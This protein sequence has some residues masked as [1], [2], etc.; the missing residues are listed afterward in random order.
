MPS[1]TWV[2]AQNGGAPWQTANGTTLSTAATATISPTTAGTGG[3]AEIFQFYQGQVFRVTASGI[4]TMGSTATN[5]TFALFASVTGTAAS[6]GTS[7]AS[8]GAFALPVSVTNLYWTIDLM[9]QVRAMAQGTGTATI[10]TSGALRLQTATFAG[11][12][13]CAVLPMPATA[14]PTAA[15]VDTTI[16][17]TMALVGT[18]SQVTGSP[19]ITCT[20]FL[21][22]SV[23]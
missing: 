22:E 3:D 10:S 23:N 7:L 20:R 14:G 18:L 16:T 4:Y 19:T 17:H 8:T 12:A 1:Q 15:N 2:A 6:G 9:A 13:N 5:A 21:I 11:S